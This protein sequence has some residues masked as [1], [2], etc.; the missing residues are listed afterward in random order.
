MG[1]EIETVNHSRL[2]CKEGLFNAFY[3]GGYCRNFSGE[4]S[5]VSLCEYYRIRRGHS[6]VFQLI[7]IEDY[8]HCVIANGNLEQFDC[9]HK[10][11]FQRIATSHM[12][13]S[14]V[15]QSPKYFNPEQ[16]MQQLHRGKTTME[17]SSGNSPIFPRKRSHSTRH[18]D[19]S[20]WNVKVCHQLSDVLR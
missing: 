1:I 18:R 20:V 9:I 19:K 8:P 12:T 7:K 2:L 3:F 11:G 17:G 4:S 14:R 15:H 10:Q 6:R 16:I 13:R 5:E